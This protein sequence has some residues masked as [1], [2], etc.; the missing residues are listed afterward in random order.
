MIVRP[1][2]RADHG[3]VARLVTAA[4][5]R[6][7]EALLVERIRASINYVPE[8]ALVAEEEGE[9]VGH[10]LLSH[11]GLRDGRTRTILE[12]APLAVAPGRQRRGVGSALVR[13]ALER[14]EDRG[15]PLV[16]VLGHAAYY[17]RFGFEP[18]RRHGIEPPAPRIPDALFM[19]RR[20]RA[21]DERYRGRVMLP[22]A[23]DVT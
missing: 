21:Y 2:R 20:L 12:L 10:V 19:V 16:A 14:A 5:E 9:V 23:F 17:P 3:A 11:V 13:A 7:N 15:E 1:E 6:P 4:F 22:P 18:A 8:L